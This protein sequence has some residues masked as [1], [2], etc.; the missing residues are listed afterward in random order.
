MMQIKTLVSVALVLVATISTATQAT[1]QSKVFESL[2][3][4]THLGTTPEWT[5]NVT[6]N[7][8]PFGKVDQLNSTKN[9]SYTKNFIL[10]P[11]TYV[12][13]ARLMKF[14]DQTG[15]APIEVSVAGSAGSAT[16]TLPVFEQKT[17]KW[18]F[19]PAVT[20]TLK[21]KGVAIFAIKNGNTS[22]TKQNY[23]FDSFRIGLV[24][25]GEVFMYQSLTHNTWFSVHSSPW[26]S[27]NTADKDSAFGEVNKLNTVWWLEFRSWKTD[28]NKNRVSNR[29]K[30]QP[31]TYTWNIRMKRTGG[32]NNLLLETSTAVGGGKFDKKTWTNF[33][34]AQN[35]WVLSPNH[36][37]V[38]TQK[39]TT[40][41]FRFWDIRSTVKSGYLFDAFVLRKGAFEPFGTA[42]TSSLGVTTLSANPPSLGGTF[43]MKVDNAPGG[44]L[45][46]IGV[47]KINLDLTA[48]GMPNC[49]LRVDPIF[50]V[51]ANAQNGIAT[52]PITVPPTASL[53]G[54]T[55][56]TQALTADP[57]I[58]AFGG[59][60]TNGATVVVGG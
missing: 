56:L 15:V 4:W 11:G 9:L 25:E 37:F 60:M 21:T 5:D 26:H 27:K 3:G 16:T 30:L 49:F 59:V 58:N 39:D 22:I 43:T 34:P 18:V 38:V 44:V 12:A 23:Y 48:A 13:P 45:F 52:L 29:L 32:T 35:Q 7:A 19:T 6:N 47:K 42:C 51:G 8:S 24:P 14:K 40:V 41:D 36:T 28:A 57:K 50:V 33:K 2:T 1:A 53:K 10:E 20:F 54:V 31:G 46:A 55:F 17:D